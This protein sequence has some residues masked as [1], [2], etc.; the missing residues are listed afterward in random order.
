MLQSKSL[1]IGAKLAVS[2]S[3]GV[4]IAATMVVVQYRSMTVSTALGERARAND[5]VQREA[6]VAE[7][8]LRR[9]LIMNRD[10]RAATT[11]KALDQSIQRMAQFVKDGQAA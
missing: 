5:L 8:A 11:D 4:V 3:I 6:I 7:L 2:A 9:V 1:R 10:S